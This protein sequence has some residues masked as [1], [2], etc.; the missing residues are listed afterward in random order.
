MSARKHQFLRYACQK[1]AHLRKVNSAFSD[2]TSLE[3]GV[4]LSDTEYSCKHK[5]KLKIMRKE[6]IFIRIAGSITVLFAL[7]HLMFYWMF[8]WK[9]ALKCLDLNNF[10]IFH[11]FN[12]IMDIMFI[13]FAVLSLFFTS[14]LIT[15][16]TGKIWLLF[17]S[18][19]Y[20]VRIICEFLLWGFNWAQSP[21]IILLCVIPTVLY[22]IPAL[23]KS[24]LNGNN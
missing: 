23:S 21:V 8:N 24:T 4:F 7:F 15:E 18:S 10:A 12:V 3:L 2:F 20:V 14:K 1:N 13:L 6:R 9:T 17:M 19:V 11:T 16:T 5:L 22:M